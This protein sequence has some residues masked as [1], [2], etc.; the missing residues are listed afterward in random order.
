MLPLWHALGSQLP[1]DTRPAV[2]ATIRR[3]YGADMHQQRLITQRPALKNI[4][5][6]NQVFMVARH[7]HPQ[8]P[9]LHADRPHPPVTLNKGVLHFWT[10]AKYALSLIH[11]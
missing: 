8:N 7:A 5:T 9:A 2:G 11:I 1:P 6:A 4:S 10:F 3:V